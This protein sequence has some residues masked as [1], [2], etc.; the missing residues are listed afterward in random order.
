MVVTGYGVQRKASFTGAAAVV[1]KDVLAKKT[2][3][4]FV[5]ALEEM[6]I[7][8]RFYISSCQLSSKFTGQHFSITS[9]AI[10]IAFIFVQ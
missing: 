2:D 8:D 10:D 1:G 3:A 6:C 5:K 9:G 4:N 7:R